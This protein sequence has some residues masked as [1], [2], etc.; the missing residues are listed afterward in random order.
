MMFSG[1]NWLGAG[2]QR[3]RKLAELSLEIILEALS[4]S[5]LAFRRS[6]LSRVRL[7][8]GTAQLIHNRLYHSMSHS[9]A[10]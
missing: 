4:C 2:R 5:L 7:F 1:G 6:P 8:G 3:H 9:S 10:L